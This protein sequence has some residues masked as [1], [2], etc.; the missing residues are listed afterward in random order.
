[1]YSKCSKTLNT[2]LFLFSNKMLVFRAG[3]LKFPVRVANR[4]DHDE[5]DS[6]E[7]V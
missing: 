6:S 4:G 5:T 2:F 7:S 1:M 3:V